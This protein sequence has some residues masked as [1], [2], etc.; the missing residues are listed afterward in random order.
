MIRV[1]VLYSSTAQRFDYDYY[2]NK[3][4]PMLLELW[5]PHGL[6]KIEINKGVAGMGPGVG[7]DYVTITV[8]TFESI[9]AMQGALAASGPKVL[10]DI[11][12]FTDVQLQVQVNEVLM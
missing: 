11:P 10:A 3:H 2:L 8:L 7:P 9:D 6:S 1:T 4:T 5:K 12:N